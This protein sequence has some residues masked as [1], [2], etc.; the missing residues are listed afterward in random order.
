V[1]G[2]TTR[3]ADPDSRGAVI[4]SHRAGASRL[5][6]RRPTWAHATPPARRPVTRFGR[7]VIEECGATGHVP[8]LLLARLAMA[9]ATAISAG[10]STPSPLGT[11][12][13]TRMH[14]RGGGMGERSAHKN[15]PMDLLLGNLVLMGCDTTNLATIRSMQSRLG[16]DRRAIPIN[17]RNRPRPPTRPGRPALHEAAVI[18]GLPKKRRGASQRFYC[19]PSREMVGREQG[20][21]SSVRCGK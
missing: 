21:R 19:R 14:G 16:G 12:G 17:Y 20:N 1:T 9:T 10:H 2:D 13:A 5:W 7:A 15:T 18:K 3:G 8:L 11:P 6:Y 4:D